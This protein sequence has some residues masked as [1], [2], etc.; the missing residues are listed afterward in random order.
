MTKTTQPDS[1]RSSSRPH[2][3]QLLVA[4]AWMAV[5]IPL[6]LGVVQT[7]NTALALFHGVG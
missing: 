6:L 2:S 3:R 4:V 7:F 1:A 5:G